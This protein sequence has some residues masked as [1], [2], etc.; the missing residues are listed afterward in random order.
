E[1]D[2]RYCHQN[3]D[4]VDG[5]NIPNRHHLLRGTPVP[6]G[7]CAVT[8]DTCERN[9]DCPGFDAGTGDIE[10]FCSVHTDRPFPAGDTS[11]N[12]DCLSC[13]K[14]Y[15]D[16]VTYTSQ[17]ETFRDCTFCHIQD[18]LAPTTH[19]R[20]TE[21]QS[22]NCKA[23][24]GPIDNPNDGH[25]VPT[26]SPSLVT[27]CTSYDACTGVSYKD[28]N[29]LPPGDAGATGGYCS[30][31][32]AASA[33]VTDPDFIGAFGA[34][35]PVVS[36][37]STHHSTGLAPFAGSDISSGKCLWC[38]D[39]T[40]AAAIRRCEDCH[41]VNSIHNI[42][43]DSTAAGNTGS[44][45]PGEEDAY[46]GHIGNNADCSG[47]H[48]FAASNAPATGPIIPQVGT[49]STYSI[50]AGSNTT[51]TITGSAF[52][53]E[54]YGYLVTSM[55]SLTDSN[56]NVVTLAPDTISVDTITVT[57]PGTLAP[58]NYVLRAVKG[59]SSS[60]ATG[61]AIIPGVTITSVSCDKKKGVLTITGSGFGTK[62]EGTDA[63][64]N[65]VINGEA[66][67]ILSWT[68]TRIKVSVSSCSGN[69]AVV[70]NA[71]Y[72]SASDSGSQP[73]KPCKGKG[74]NK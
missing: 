71:L 12:Y 27:P 69:T 33:G 13:H 11:G 6:S 48:G 22:K 4:I 58:G 9:E 72:G 28:V 57:I 16:P 70:V 37:A 1:A 17:F 7:T 51:I 34:V 49:L 29:D 2:C 62:P 66:S 61:L 45:V 43:V 47:C 24:H 67:S 46:W 10:N 73:S 59:P 64:I 32:H 63:D 54:I 41:G 68:D 5:A 21:A 53:N 52:T 3:E 38:H 14:L 23:C 20:T 31:C 15:W 60:N 74:C 40:A 42:Q 25:Y 35:V 56:G 8:A 65:V 50:T 30:F 18:P 39:I 26:Y 44:I 36:N 55:V 19:H